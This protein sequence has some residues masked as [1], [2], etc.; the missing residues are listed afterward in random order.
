M[1]EP[2]CV[3]EG[4]A[5]GIAAHDRNHGILQTALQEMEPRARP[6]TLSRHARR[7][8]EPRWTAREKGQVK[9]IHGHAV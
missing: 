1:R 5:P 9:R 6:V 2:L 7:A 3:I 4:K 8:R